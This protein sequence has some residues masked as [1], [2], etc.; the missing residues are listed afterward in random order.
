M[1]AHRASGSQAGTLDE[2]E[3]A[4][5]QWSRIDTLL[6]RLVT[7]LTYAAEGHAAPL[8]LTLD[9]IRSEMRNATDESTIE[10]LL[11][12]LTDAVRSLDDLVSP[13]PSVTL[14][15]PEISPPDSAAGRDALL[16]VLDR[17]QLDETMLP[18]LGTLRAAIMETHELGGLAQ[19]AEA[20]ASVVNRQ[21]RQ[22][23]EHRQAAETLLAHVTEQLVEL[24]EYVTRE[25][26]DQ[27]DGSGARQ[28]LDHHLIHEI[29]AL[30]SQ[31]RQTNDLHFLRR[32]VESRIGAISTHMKA[33][34]E[35]EEK[36]ERDWQ[37]RAQQMTQR[38]RELEHA[39]QSMELS[40]SQKQQQAATDPLTGIANRRVY[41]AHIGEI[42]EQVRQHTAEVCLLVLDIDHFK[43]INDRFGHAAGDRA[44]RIVA[45]QLKARLRAGDL[46]ARYGGE[47]FV[48]VLSGTSAQAGLRIAET[49][50]ATIEGIGFRGQQQPVSITLSCGVT[51]VQ[52]DD[53]A[54]SVFERADRALYLAKRRG[55][56]RCEM[57]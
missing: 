17:L 26:A 37:A 49:L 36:R 51:Q 31:M 5:A 40:L 28:Q 29:D 56:N 8:D 13:T 35:R 30:G 45:D 14:P 1:N 57:G 4:L 24:T 34:R 12:E 52:P 50:R 18:Y 27:R 23:G 53:T 20:L 7:R 25:N 55:R 2:D 43:H 9:K 44:L 21:I 33:F 19:Q 39:A 15:P 10:Q 47:E 42:C 11:H 54:N 16:A 3:N 32:E 48:A 22:L 38:I 46:L 6:R 41:E